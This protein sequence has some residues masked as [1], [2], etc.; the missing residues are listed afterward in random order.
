MD[1]LKKLYY[2]RVTDLLMRYKLHPCTEEDIA[3]L[4]EH[5]QRSIPHAY[6]TF[7]RKFGRN[8]ER[9]FDDVN[10][11]RGVLSTHRAVLGLLKEN[12]VDISVLPSDATVI[13]LN[14]QG[15]EFT[16]IRASEGDN[17]PVW[18][19]LEY[20]D[21]LF[22]KI[23][24]SFWEYAYRDITRNRRDTNDNLSINYEAEVLEIVRDLMW[25]EHISKWIA[26]C[27]DSE[28]DALEQDVGSSL[29][30]AYKNFLA[31]MGNSAPYFLDGR[32]SNYK[33]LLS[34]KGHIAREY[35]PLIPSDGF[36]FACYY[37]WAYHGN[38]DFDFFRL[39][40]GDDPPVYHCYF[41]GEKT[42]TIQKVSESFSAYLK[43]AIEAIA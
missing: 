16:F 11:F 37:T 12:R 42:T 33:S 20:E 3:F 22:K 14:D 8:D 40:E 24:D 31:W 25:R 15:Y 43:R 2:Q 10:P 26:P 41:D 32:Y 5:I 19:Y 18:H 7:L 34:I 30:L 6:K 23:A 17:P 38:K 28:I 4:E 27:S 1:D 29:P 39:S 21:I 13:W 36:V 9:I 35:T